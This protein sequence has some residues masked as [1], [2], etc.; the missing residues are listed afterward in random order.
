[1]IGP[2][3][4]YLDK[5]LV[6]LI[7][8]DKNLSFLPFAALVSP[9][10]GK[11]LVEDYT[12][13]IAPSAT[14]FIKA[15]QQAEQLHATRSNDSEEALVVG[16][17]YFD[18]EEFG[19]LPDLPQARREAEQVAQLYTIKPLLGNE[20]TSS[21]VKRL[22]N[23]AEV[24]H[25]ATHAVPDERSPLLSKLLLSKEGPSE[26]AHHASRGFLQGTEI[27]GMKFTRTRLVVLSACQTGIERAYR[28]EG[29][30]GLARPFIAGVPLVVASLWPVESGVTADLMISFHKHRKQDPVSTVEALRRA[31]LDM[32]QKQLPNSPRDY[33]WAAFVT[34][35]GYAEF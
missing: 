6:L 11:H 33:G 14:V 31:Q 2:I 15:S 22:L 8:P 9:T 3:E 19:G 5:S 30:I 23:T 35:G 27:Y 20:A 1:V 21:L 10:S 7:V 32:L 24:I 26:Q 12:I 28:G 29:A 13:Q 16:N 17:P 18:R 4:H 34:I 25:L